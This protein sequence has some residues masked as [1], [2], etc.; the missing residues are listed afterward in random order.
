MA[1]PQAVSRSASARRAAAAW[2][3]LGFVWGATWLFIKIGLADVPPFTY[4]MLR[5]SIA[6][7]PLALVMR[8]RG[9]RF[10]RRAAEWRLLV[11]TGLLS[12]PVGYG[13][14]YVGE[15]RISAGLTAILFTTMPLFGLVFAHLLVK[16]ERLTARS[17]VGVLLGV[18]GVAMIFG[19]QL[20][21][22]DGSSLWGAVAVVVSAASSALA[23][24]LIKRAGAQLDPLVITVVQMGVGLPPMLALALLLEGNPLAIHLTA[25]VLLS[26][27]YLAFVGSS[28]AFVVWY[29]LI[30][31]IEV[32]RA[33][34][35][36]LF[37][38]LVAVLLGAVVL[39]EQMGWN[40]VTGGIA[41]LAGLAVSVW[42][43]LSRSRVS[44]MS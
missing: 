34:L 23:A 42:P 29:W 14:V 32:T 37:N 5:F 21:L 19:D 28:L 22:A 35:L 40:Q 41:I 4:A 18:G 33:Q 15:E 9:A 8:L 43:E 1:V 31:T 3:L 38:T 25:R 16:A 30:R 11:V 44:A 26:L 36:P 17:V 2:L 10:P 7:A 39:G 13:L 6:I 27:G 24:V 12:F 20:W